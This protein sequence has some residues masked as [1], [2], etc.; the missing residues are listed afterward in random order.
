MPTFIY[1]A[2]DGPGR[3]VGGE[4]RAE[5]RAAAVAG[6]DAKGYS[7]IWVREQTGTARRGGRGRR[8]GRRD[9]ILFTRQ[10]AS[11]V[12]SS[13]PIL[14]ALT[15]VRDQTENG[16]MSR[17]VEDLETTIRNGE[18]LS[19]ALSK[20]PALFSGLYV[21]MVRAGESAGILDKILQR[22]SEALES[23]EEMRRKVQAATAYPLLILGVGAATIFVLFAFFLPRV[24]GLFP[25]HQS[26]PMPTRILVGISNVFS[27]YWYWIVFG[28]FLLV[29]V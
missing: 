20:Y 18:M 1:K 17:V 28:V 14:R 23:E 10:L 15:T 19:G 29:A 9:V 25:D 26:L 5:S 6:L 13:V 2:K 12:K 3:T 8:I 24:V 22:L 21:N 27:A 16:R 4:I 7:P 11:L